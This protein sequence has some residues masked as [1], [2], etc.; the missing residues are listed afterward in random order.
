MARSVLRN[1]L[2]E[3]RLVVKHA[4]WYL[5]MTCGL[6]NTH[7]RADRIAQRLATNEG[8]LL[9]VTLSRPVH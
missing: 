2:G 8:R 3:L 9:G 6:V 1:Y 7:I 5:R 4:H